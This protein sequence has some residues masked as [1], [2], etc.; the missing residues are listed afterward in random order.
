M[1][2]ERNPKEIFHDSQELAD[3]LR[4]LAPDSRSPYYLSEC[5]EHIEGMYKDL[6]NLQGER[7][8]LRDALAVMVSRP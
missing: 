5:A 1:R 8:A 4:S 2:K 6:C 3:A 7:D